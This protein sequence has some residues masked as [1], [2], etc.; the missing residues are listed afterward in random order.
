MDEPSQTPAAPWVA[1]E[2]DP[3]TYVEGY[4]FASLRS[5]LNCCY[6]SEL[7][8]VVKITA[9]GVA[10]LVQDAF[11]WLTCEME[12]KHVHNEDLRRKLLRADVKVSCSEWYSVILRYTFL[13]QM[14]GLRERRMQADIDKEAIQRELDVA[15]ASNRSRNRNVIMMTTRYLFIEISAVINKKRLRTRAKT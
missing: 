12:R 10:K 3:V 1:Y 8:T 5:V 2:Q 6:M 14:N 9:P 13:S 11:R 4:R 15:L 7:L